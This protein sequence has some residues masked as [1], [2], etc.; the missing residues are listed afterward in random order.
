MIARRAGLRAFPGRRTT[1]NTHPNATRRNQFYLASRKSL[2]LQMVEGKG[3][4]P[5]PVK[6]GA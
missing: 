5:Q 1:A 4:D 3:F 2:L 6:F